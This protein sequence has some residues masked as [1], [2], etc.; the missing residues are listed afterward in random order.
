MIWE[1]HS[2]LEGKHAVLGASQYAWLNYKPGELRKKLRPK[3]APRIGTLLHQLA[4]EEYIL[5]SKRMRRED[6]NSVKEYLIEE[7]IPKFAINMNLYFGNLCRYIND[8]VKYNMDP[9]KI[10]SYSYNCFGTADAISFVDNFLRIHDLKT[11][12]GKVS[13][14]QLRI[15]AAL[16]CLEYEKEPEDIE[17]ELRIYQSP[18]I[19]I[20]RCESEQIRKI[21]DTIVLFDRK[22]NHMGR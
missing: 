19:L 14:K 7:G 6:R 10:L 8:A 1:E 16:F 15:Y 9:E 22:I 21:M 5:K 18:E 13:M 3:Y 11:G 20:E 4:S 12:F 2:D 17:V